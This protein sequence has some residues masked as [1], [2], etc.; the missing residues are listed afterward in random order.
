MSEIWCP[1]PARVA[2]T[3][4][5]RFIQCVGARRGLTLRSY[6]DLYAWSIERSGEFWEEMA[7]FADIC[8]EW[9]A[10]RSSRMRNACQ[11]RVSFRT[12]A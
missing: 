3:N 2:N 7:Q 11:E 10:G 8:A 4:L 1:S 9:A 5:T 6:S 12:R